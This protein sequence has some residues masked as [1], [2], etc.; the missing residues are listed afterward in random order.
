M[1]KIKYASLIYKVGVY[2][3]LV[4][5]GISLIIFTFTEGNFNQKLVEFNA[6]NLYNGIIALEPLLLLYLASLVLVIS[7]IVAI[8]YVMFYYF[9]VRQYSY[10]FIS[11]FLV[12][13]T[14]FLI[15]FKAT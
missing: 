11:L 8:I 9:L 14:I 6:Y 3:S 5:I 1:D 15:I 13:I 7:P 2:V 4:L 10:F 12:L